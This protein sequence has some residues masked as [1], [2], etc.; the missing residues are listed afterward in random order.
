MIRN[1][2]VRVDREGRGDARIGGT[3]SRPAVR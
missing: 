3:L 1:L 2:G